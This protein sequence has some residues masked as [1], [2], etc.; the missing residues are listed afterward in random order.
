[1]QII[2]IRQSDRAGSSQNKADEQVIVRTLESKPPAVTHWSTRTMAG[3]SGINQIA[4][5][6]IWR[7]F[8]LAPHRSE[9]F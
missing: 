4:I 5:S 1:L 9:T 6:R 7:A 2:C 8:S 3:A